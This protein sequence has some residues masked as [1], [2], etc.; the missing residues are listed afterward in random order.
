M[1][2]LLCFFI[3]ISSFGGLTIVND[4]GERFA[5]CWSG[6]VSSEPFNAQVDLRKCTKGTIKTSCGTC[7]KRVQ[8]PTPISEF[9]T[10][11][12]ILFDIPA[13]YAGQDALERITRGIERVSQ[14]LEDESLEISEKQGIE[15]KVRELKYIQRRI[16]RLHKS[17]I[18]PLYD[19]SQISVVD[20]GTVIEPTQKNEN[21]K[22]FFAFDPITEISVRVFR[23]SQ[24]NY[25]Y[26]NSDS[27]C[28]SPF[29]LAMTGDILYVQNR[30]RLKR[31]LRTLGERISSYATVVI[32]QSA[33]PSSHITFDFMTDNTYF[34]ANGSFK[35][36]CVWPREP[37]LVLRK[38]SKP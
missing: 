10:N 25:S 7:T 37:E 18:G 20:A 33:N 23:F 17:V 24:E 32:A 28:S 5:V 38:A 29:K 31:Y 35:A 26:A 30:S 6:T 9:L 22:V 19:T 21:Q 4:L 14:E 16:V 36:L 3:S 15:T 11:L 8:P 2:I 1:K 13:D 27:G 12:S 34:L